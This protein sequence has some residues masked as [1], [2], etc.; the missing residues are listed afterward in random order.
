M[1]KINIIAVGNLKE[2]YWTEAIEEYKKRLSR[3]AKVEI[4]E[5]AEVLPN[6]RTSVDQIK[7]LECDEL[8][9][10]L[11]GVG[12][13]MDKSGKQLTSEEFA[14]FIETQFANGAKAINTLW[15]MPSF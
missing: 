2:K 10:H 1:H 7:K 12:V 5:V 3:F 6:S 15:S 8:A 13:A 4:K 9:K 11:V 14:K